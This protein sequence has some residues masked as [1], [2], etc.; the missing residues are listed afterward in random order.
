[1]VKKIIA[2]LFILAAWGTIVASILCYLARYISPEWCSWLPFFGLFYP[3]WLFLQ[4]ALAAWCLKYK[5]QIFLYL[6]GVFLL[7]LGHLGGI[8]QWQ[9]HAQ[10]R[11][12][13]RNSFTIMSHNTE[14]LLNIDYQYFGLKNKTLEKSVN[15]INLI[16]KFRPNILCLQESVWY[17]KFTDS[18]AKKL[19]QPF[20]YPYSAYANRTALLIYSDFP[21]LRFKHFIKTNNASNGAIYADL[22]VDNKVIIRVFNIHLQSNKL[23][24]NADRLITNI[25]NINESEGRGVYKTAYHRLRDTWLIRAKQVNEIA[26]SIARSPY[27]VVIV[28]D[29][30][31]TPSSYSYQSLVNGRQDGFKIGGRWLSF[32]YN[33]LLPALSIDHIFASNDLPVLGFRVIREGKSDH[34]PVRAEIGY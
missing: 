7:G 15:E 33:G 11:T 6:L 10:P 32:T 27:P 34:F 26:D 8:F 4:L 23:G 31:D 12:S 21:I 1:M 14:G 2:P 25:D 16:K 29:F 13:V 3:I 28:G 17:A 9:R 22:Q 30:N 5:K 18:L 20:V 19:P 24:K